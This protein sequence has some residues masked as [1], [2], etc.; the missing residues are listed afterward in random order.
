MNGEIKTTQTEQEIAA[1]DPELLAVQAIEFDDTLVAQLSKSVDAYKKI[2][3]IAI[4]LTN[5]QDWVNQNGK[6]YLQCSGAEKIASPFLVTMGTP[7]RERLERDDDK[8]KSYIWVY[9]AQF[10]SRRLGRSIV[11]QGKCSS[12]DQFFGKSK[13]GTYKPYDEIKEEDVMQA[14]YT[15]C[16]G[17]GVTR[18]LGIR[19]LT[20]QQLAEGGISQ[21]SIGKVEYQKG[22]TAEG[23]QTELISDPQRKRLFAIAKQNAW[24]DEDLKVWLKKNYNIEHT[25]QVRRSQ[26]DEICKKLELGPGGQTNGN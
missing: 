6:P 18:L 17:N 20:W 14:A 3:G 25:N 10:T 23:A 4:R 1:V 2:I 13:D 22:Q 9:E 21:N 24:D 19:N 7:R 12:R 8:G 26:Y 15:N 11:A 16:F 5:H